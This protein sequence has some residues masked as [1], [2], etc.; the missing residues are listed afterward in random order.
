MQFP[1]IGLAEYG[2]AHFG[3]AKYGLADS[4]IADSELAKC[5]LAR[6]A[7]PTSVEATREDK[8]EGLLDY[9][10]LISEIKQSLLFTLPG[11]LNTNFAW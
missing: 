5:G 7:S 1:E 3:L 8:Q 2:L 10:N 11:S 4:C 9:S 6:Y